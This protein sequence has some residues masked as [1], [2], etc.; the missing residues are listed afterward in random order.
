MLNFIREHLNDFRAFLKSTDFSRAILLGIALTL[1]V[2]LGIVFDQLQIGI[3]ITVGALL[4]SPSD[5]SGNI[6]NKVTGILLSALLA[7]TMSII[8]GSLQFSPWILFPII[9]VLIFGISYISIFGFRASLISFSGLFALVLSFSPVSGDMPPVERAMFIGIG[10]LWYAAMAILWH[11]IFP[12]GPTEFYLSQTFNLTAEYLRIRG[13]LISEKENRSE[14][15]KRLLQVQTEITETHETLR[16]ILISRRTD[17]G[18]SVYEGKRLLIFAQL[19]DMLELAMANPVNYDKT[20]QI[21][22]RHPKYLAHFQDLL[23]AMAN[24]LD[25]CGEAVFNIKALPND[26]VLQTCLMDIKNELSQVAPELS[27]E[28]NKELLMLRN[29]FKYQSE[30]VK[31][32]QKIEWL[33]RERD[34]SRIRFITNEEARRFLTRETYNIEVF[35]ENFNFNSSI[36]KHSLRLA[37]VAIIGYAVGI[38]FEVQ[39]SYWILLTLIVIMRPNFGLTK[40]R[41]MERTIGTLIGGAL[42]VIIVLLIK[43]PWVYG[44]LSIVTLVI[45]FAMIQRNYRAAATFITLS[46]VFS[47]ALLNPN[48]FDVIKYRVMDT[49]IG[50]GLAIVG[51]LILWPAWEIRSIQKTLLETLKANRNYFCEIVEY[52]QKKEDSHEYKIARK[53]AFLKMSNLNSAF[54][55]MTQEPKS[56]QKNLDKFYQLVELNHNFLAS[57][58]SLGTYILNNPTTPASENFNKIAAEITENLER[59]ENILNEKAHLNEAIEN[60]AAAILEATFGRNYIL[61]EYDTQIDEDFHLRMEEAHLVGEQL[62][63]LLA[64]SEKMQKLLL[65]TPI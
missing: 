1:P 48:I 49:V 11:Y 31:K 45:S 4:A 18:R 28:E 27:E 26:T 59:C 47:F 39:N 23:F 56:Q 65:E 36:F 16:D 43:N 34:K 20:D 33:F 2:V 15:F 3:V 41:S 30:Q 35:I 14:L 24:R 13:K 60:Q 10:G 38:V 44:I 42:A 58:A 21:F 46:V 50:T 63:W 5:T 22:E 57:L 9:G 61:S 64:M 37:V 53:Q 29:L 17:S 19:I 8:G 7:V 6:R 62:Q 32:I 52:Y 51:N 12:K 25:A 40:Q 54:Q 55:R